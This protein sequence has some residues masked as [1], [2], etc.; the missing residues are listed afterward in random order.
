VAEPYLESFFLDEGIPLEI[1]SND[2]GTF[3]VVRG[4]PRLHRRSV[5]C[6]KPHQQ[7]QLGR[8]SSFTVISTPDQPHTFSPAR[9]LGWC[10]TRI[11]GEQFG[12][13]SLYGSLIGRK[14][15]KPSLVL[16]EAL[17]VVPN[18]REVS[19]NVPARLIPIEQGPTAIQSSISNLNFKTSSGLEIA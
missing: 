16:D 18:L 1:I 7:V 13:I 11:R 3:K 4:T 10:R 12:F 14:F 8:F 17:T 6:D 15:L 2:Y 5:T 19:R 9:F